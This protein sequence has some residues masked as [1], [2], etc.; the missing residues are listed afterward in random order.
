MSYII[1]PLEYT[2]EGSQSFDLGNISVTLTPRFNYAAGCWSLDILD[3]TGANLANG[4]M[5]VPNTDLLLG[6]TDLKL[7]IGSLV[8]VE[9]NV[10]DYKNP[11]SIGYNMQLLWYPYGTEIT[12]PT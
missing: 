8:V 1:L 9:N 5:M 2:G 10:D 12:L 4:L 11:E 6:L 7:Q 3:A